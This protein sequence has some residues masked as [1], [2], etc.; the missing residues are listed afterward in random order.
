MLNYFVY[1]D[2]IRLTINDSSSQ[3][4]ISETYINIFFTSY[5][6][7]FL[8][9]FALLKYYDVGRYWYVSLSSWSNECVKEFKAAKQ[10]GIE[11]FRPARRPACDD[12]DNM[13]DIQ[14]VVKKLVAVR[15]SVTNE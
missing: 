10:R 6:F 1:I 9:V 14:F 12:D 4:D 2:L 5:L 15:L 11:A 7:H 8:F 3:C 13:N